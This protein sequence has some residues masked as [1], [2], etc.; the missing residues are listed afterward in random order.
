MLDSPSSIPSNLPSNNVCKLVCLVSRIDALLSFNARIK[1]SCLCINAT[2][3]DHDRSIVIIEQQQRREASSIIS[4][5]LSL[6]SSLR[7]RRR[8]TDYENKASD[9]KP[10]VRTEL[11]DEILLKTD[12]DD[13]LDELDTCLEQALEMLQLQ[14]E[15]EQFVGMR[16]KRYQ[17]VL[18]ER[19]QELLLVAAQPQEVEV[20]TKRADQTALCGSDD[21]AADDAAAHVHDEYDNDEE[22]GKPELSPEERERQLTKLQQDLVAL[23]KVELDYKILQTH[24]LSLQKRV[25]TLERQRDVILHKTAECQE[26]LIAAAVVEGR[27]EAGFHH[28]HPDDDHTEDGDDDTPTDAALTTTGGGIPEVMLQDEVDDIDEEDIDDESSDDDEYSQTIK[29]ENKDDCNDEEDSGG[30]NSAA[31]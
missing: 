20:E 22:V 14:K 27:D 8:G 9:M 3:C 18:K 13:A 15:K 6:L 12:N 4:H 11:T 23:K 21:A 10:H 5:M 28:H 29:V 17:T 24:T 26:F 31:E 1:H 7:N 30:G 16:L 19:S 25:Y 2:F